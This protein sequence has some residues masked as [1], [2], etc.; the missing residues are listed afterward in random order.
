M[1]VLAAYNH[2]LPQRLNAG[3][4]VGDSIDDHIAARAVTDGAEEPARASPGAVPQQPDARR[5]QRRS[6]GLA[7]NSFKAAP[8]KGELNHARIAKVEYRVLGDTHGIPP[9][10]LNTVSNRLTVELDMLCKENA[11]KA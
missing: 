6:D 11:E 7:L 10:R 1:A 4:N 5:M 8:L 2:A 3:A 9:G